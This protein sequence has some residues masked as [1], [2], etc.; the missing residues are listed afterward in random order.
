MAGFGS[1]EGGQGKLFRKRDCWAEFQRDSLMSLTIYPY[2]R[3]KKKITQGQGKQQDEQF[4]KYT[5]SCKYVCLS[6]LEKGDSK[7]VIS[8]IKKS[9]QEKKDTNNINTCQNKAQH[10][11]K[12]YQKTK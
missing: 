3:D 7:T 2:T 9:L 1:R 10:S 4:L 8:K 11:L 6:A 5:Q 12:E